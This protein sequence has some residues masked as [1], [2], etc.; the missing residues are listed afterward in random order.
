M[1]EGV[2]VL[3][4]WTRTDFYALQVFEKFIKRAC[5]E[6]NGRWLIEI[7]VYGLILVPQLVISVTPHV[8][9]CFFWEAFSW[10]TTMTILANEVDNLDIDSHST[11]EECAQIVKMTQSVSYFRFVKFDLHTR[12]Q[13]A[14]RDQLS[15]FT[16]TKPSNLSSSSLSNSTF[17]V[18]L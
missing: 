16:S 17:N 4:S 14:V 6:I 9:T 8:V 11:N 5:S 10:C 7:F 12:A 13:K 15:S 2:V 1:P 18:N 3:F